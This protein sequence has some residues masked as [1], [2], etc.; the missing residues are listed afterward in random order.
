[1]TSW[2]FCVPLATTKVKETLPAIQWMIAQIENALKAK[3]VFRLH[4]DK[5]MELQ[6][7]AVRKWAASCGIV[8]TTTGGYEPAANGRAERTV[9]LIKS[10]ARAM[11]VPILTVHTLS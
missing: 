3:V 10:K 8:V 7:P 6:G 5:A 9:G 11:I 1:M 4:S 2:H